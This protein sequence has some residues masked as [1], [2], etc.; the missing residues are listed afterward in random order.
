MV[1]ETLVNTGSGN[2]LLPD[3][4]N[5]SPEAVLSYVQRHPLAFL[6]GWY[7]YWNTQ[8]INP[9]IAFEIYTF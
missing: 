8:D 3:G 9:Q 5:Q 2:G 4:I 6:P 1:S 7:I